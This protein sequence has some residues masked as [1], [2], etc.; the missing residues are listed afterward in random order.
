M[1]LQTEGEF[2]VLWLEDPAGFEE[3]KFS[4]H[5]IEEEN[6]IQM[7]AGLKTGKSTPSAFALLFMRDKG[8]DRSKAWD[9]LGD[10]PEY[11]PW[12]IREALAKYRGPKTILK[13]L[14]N[15]K[16]FLSEFFTVKTIDKAKGIHSFSGFTADS[17]QRQVVALVFNGKDW[18]RE[19]AEQ[20]L[21]SRQ[22]KVFRRG[23]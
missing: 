14:R 7:I 6:G 4:A 12:R 11:L 17:S 23:R 2:L 5:W 16:P 9:W 1:G 20:W 3:D 10:H 19:K 18:T 21:E 22:G 8:W 13:L 15:P